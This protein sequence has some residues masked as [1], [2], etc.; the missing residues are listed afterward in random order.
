MEKAQN[1]IRKTTAFASVFTVFF[2]KGCAC[3][4]AG[5]TTYIYMYI[6]IY[7]YMYVIMWI[8]TYIDGLIDR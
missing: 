7:V 2:F 6:C 5:V 3:C 8:D 1:W 4:R